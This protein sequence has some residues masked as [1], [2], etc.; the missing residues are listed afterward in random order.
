MKYSTVNDDCLIHVYDDEDNCYGCGQSSAYI[1]EQHILGSAGIFDEEY[2]N[3][4]RNR[5][6]NKKGMISENQANQG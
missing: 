6:Q 1:I 2:M 4:L 5:K 3:K